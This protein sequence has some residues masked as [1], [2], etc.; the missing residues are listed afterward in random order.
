MKGI[1]NTMTLEEIRKKIDE[2]DKELFR[3]FEQRMKLA[4]EVAEAKKIS[5]DN[6]YKPLREEEVI[7][8]FAENAPDDMKQYYKAF[9]R[10]VMLISREYQY[11]IIYGG[12]EKV[13]NEYSEHCSDKNIEISFKC[14]D[15]IPD[16]IIAALADAGVK[17]DEFNANKGNYNIVLRN[18]ISGEN[19]KALLALIDNEAME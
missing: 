10:R 2:T 13:C 19:I 7:E 5:G 9:I 15:G 17:V 1:S 3:L 16:G 12:N 4:K 11:R 8:K 6:V 14:T 18:D